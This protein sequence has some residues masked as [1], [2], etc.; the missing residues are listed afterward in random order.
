MKTKT[1]EQAL[2]AYKAGEGRAGQNY[3]AGVQATTG[4]KEAAIAGEATYAAA[5]QESIANKKRARRLEETAEEKWKQNAMNKGVTRIGPGMK[6]AEG[7]YARGMSKVIS[8]IA[9]TDLPAR[10]ADSDTNID[11]RVKPLARALKAAFK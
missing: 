10:T 5:L 9:A 6:A 1:A 2:L 4:W 11:N 7:D 3:G 8:V